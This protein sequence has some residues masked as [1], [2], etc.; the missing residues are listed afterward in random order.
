MIILI[1]I[2]FRFYSIYFIIYYKVLIVKVNYYCCKEMYIEGYSK[3]VNVSFLNIY[4]KL[5]YF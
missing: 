5:C 4:M 3:W 2:S 1:K